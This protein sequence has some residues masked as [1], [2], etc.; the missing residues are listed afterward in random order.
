RVA[1]RPEPVPVFEPPAPDE[2][3]REL[4]LETPE[5]PAVVEAEFEPVPLLP[6]EGAAVAATLTVP[7]EP[8]LRS[9][10]FGGT[11]SVAGSAP[12]GTDRVAQG[13]PPMADAPSAPAAPVS[14]RQGSGAI[15]RTTPQPEY[16][17]L[18]RRR[19]EQGTVTLR[20]S[21]DDHGVVAHVELVE[22]SGF[23]R[24]DEAA[25]AGV[26]AWRFEPATEASG[27]PIDSEVLWR[28][29]FELKSA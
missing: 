7:F 12:S 28:V 22:S 10:R 20:I 5:D 3:P 13:A 23:R 15:A 29:V 9:I 1:E 11:K 21:V 6:L 8:N 14:G 17:P 24:L 26:R 16:P 25:I 2:E 4:E 27:A 19:G 18:S